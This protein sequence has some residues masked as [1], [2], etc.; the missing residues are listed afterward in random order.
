MYVTMI[1]ENREEKK[2]KKENER[3]KFIQEVARC[4]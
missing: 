4:L 2:F 3:M 1:N